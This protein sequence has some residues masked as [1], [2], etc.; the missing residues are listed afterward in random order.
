MNINKNGFKSL[1]SVVGNLSLNET[2]SKQEKRLSVSLM[3]SQTSL[4]STS[5]SLLSEMK[6]KIKKTFHNEKVHLKKK[7]KQRCFIM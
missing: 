7:I 3:S 1:I 2:N 5:S 4:S 6:D